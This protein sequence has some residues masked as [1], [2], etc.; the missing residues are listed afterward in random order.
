[1][2]LFC[3]KGGLTRCDVCAMCTFVFALWIRFCFGIWILSHPMN[4]WKEWIQ[5]NEPGPW[6]FDRLTNLP[7]PN[8]KNTSV[9]PSVGGE[10][11]RE[12]FVRCELAFSGRKLI[13]RFVLSFY[14]LG[15]QLRQWNFLVRFFT[16]DNL[17]F[18]LSPL[19]LSLLF[20]FE[21]VTFQ[22]SVAL[23]KRQKFSAF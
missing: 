9:E 10:I 2:K 8:Q 22:R 6:L 14:Q 23:D 15:W 17:F 21:G 19:F 20:S 16:F 5:S 4:D 18:R 11:E 3:W 12:I 13:T 7:W 1:M